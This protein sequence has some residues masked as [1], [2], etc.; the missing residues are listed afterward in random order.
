[1]DN[2]K[3]FSCVIIGEG[4]LPVQ[5]GEILLTN[6]HNICGV[7]SPSQSV[8]RWADEKNISHADMAEDLNEFLGKL[9]FDFLFSIVNIINYQALLS[10]SLELPRKAAI[11]YHDALLPTYAG[12]FPTSW[13]LMNREVRHGVTWHLMTE[14]IDAG[15]IL[16]QWPV[17]ISDLDTAFTL[18]AK[19]YEAAILSFAALIQDLAADQAHPKKQDLGRRTFFP[20]HQR[21]PERIGS[22]K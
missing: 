18:N 22:K 8:N 12:F 7:I 9:Q 17:E 11:N 13:A 10:A 1:M 2:F 15:D 21:P 20:L 19:C 3:H 14:W 16:K 4:S 5:C 6:G